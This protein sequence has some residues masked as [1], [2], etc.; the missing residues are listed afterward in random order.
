MKKISILLI[1]LIAILGFAW[2][3]GNQR[4]SRLNRT[5]STVK[6]RE[7]LFP[8]FDVNGIKKIRIK[9]D[10]SE[11]TLVVQNDTWV[12]QERS[13]FPIDKEKL[14]TA[15]LS[16]QY[17][18]I[19]A[20]RRIGKDS[21]GKI[22]LNT[23]DAG[24]GAGTLV[25]LFDDKG[26]LKHTLVLGGK[27]T[28]SGGSSNEQLNMFGGG[29]GNRFV[30][31]VGEDTV[32]E[33]GE[34]LP[35]LVSKPEAWLSK[36]FID[37]QKIKSVEV[38][39]AK[40]E[41]SWKATRTDE[42]AD[43]MLTDAKAGEKLDPG[44]A[45]LGALFSSATFNDV[46]PKDKAAGVMKDAVKFKIVTFQGFTYDF[47]TAKEAAQPGSGA[48]K[49]YL[50]VSV[51]ADLPKERAAA[52]DEKPEDKKSK[53]EAFAAE[54]KALQ[55]KLAAEQKATA[56]W[57]F[58]VSEYSVSSLFKKRSEILA[59]PEK[60]STPAPGAPGTNPLPDVK[61]MLPGI[62]PGAGSPPPVSVTTPP[63]SLTT[64]PTQMPQPPKVELKPAPAPDA[65]PVPGVKPAAEPA[66]AK[67]AAEPA[68]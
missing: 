29:S 43:F 67:P 28:S 19:K 14:Q 33:I 24:Y 32:W 25:E 9:E 50:T 63:V 68:K 21:L 56:G 5:L 16:L 37:V 10:K 47:Q 7:L 59:P 1:A 65:S 12:V 38:T 60:S 52:K 55:E 61:K 58:D 54:K 35:D 49:Y 34:Q 13:G 36:A 11:T 53:D 6:L 66:P 64:Q 57:T 41:D 15:L 22:G 30:R 42:N 40:A 62:I 4:K 51:S 46:L 18:K 17:E 3:Q 23:P 39:F 27:V 45:S 8:D 26:G 48:D 2:Y 20:G 44:K 31:V